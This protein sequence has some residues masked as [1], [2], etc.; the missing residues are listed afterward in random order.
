MTAYTTDGALLQ[1]ETT[2]GSGVFVTIP[3]VMT[4][5]PPKRTRKTVDVAIHDQDT[6][7]SLTGGREAQE[8]T[9]TVAWDPG[10]TYHQDLFADEDAK[11]SRNYKIVLPDTGA[12]VAAFAASIQD[13]DPG[14]L[15]A[16][17]TEALQISFV[18]KLS[19]V[20]SWTW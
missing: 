10:N 14:E 7:I 2:P 11:T 4:F 5:K 19:A 16:E 1:R 15:S 3:Q 13:L 6:P 8:V 18:L 17:G 20:E 9:A 12:A